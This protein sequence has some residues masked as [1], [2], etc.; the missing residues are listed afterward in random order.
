MIEVRDVL[1]DPRELA[2]DTSDLSEALLRF[3]QISAGC[4]DLRPELFHV[5]PRQLIVGI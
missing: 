1:F 4:G 5:P 2:D 3:T